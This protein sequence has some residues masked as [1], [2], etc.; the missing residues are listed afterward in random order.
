MGIACVGSSPA[1]GTKTKQGDVAKWLRQR[2][3]KP[4]SAVR[5]R[6]SPPTTRPVELP[7]THTEAVELL[8]SFTDSFPNIPRV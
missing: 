2:S 1:L 3:A 5:I 8:H 7:L 6:P 4:P